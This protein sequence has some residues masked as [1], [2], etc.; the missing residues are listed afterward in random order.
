MITIGKSFDKNTE[1]LALI[2]LIIFFLFNIIIILVLNFRTCCLKF[3]HEI[4]VYTF[5]RAIIGFSFMNCITCIYINYYLLF[6]LP[7]C[8]YKSFIFINLYFLMMDLV[9]LIMILEDVL[10]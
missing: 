4:Y 9:L 3:Y 1:Q 8:L 7:Y 5:A 2:V 10:F 6:I